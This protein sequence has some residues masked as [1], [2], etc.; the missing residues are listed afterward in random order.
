VIALIRL[1]LK[2]DGLYKAIAKLEAW[3]VQKVKAVRDVV[4][5]TA[6]NI[7]KGAKRNCPVNTGRLRSSIAIEPVTSNKMVLRVGTYVKYAADVEF[8]TRPHKIVPKNKKALFWRGA[9]HPVKSVNHPGSRAKPFLFPAYEA[10]RP[11]FTKA[12]REALSE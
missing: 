5:E 11:A 4:N 7:Q 3:E 8:G 2:L 6:L 9:R 1:D 12:L 10:E